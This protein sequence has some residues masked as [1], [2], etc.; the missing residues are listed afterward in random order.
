MIRFSESTIQPAA[1]DNLVKQLMEQVG[2]PDSY[3]EEELRRM[4]DEGCAAA[5][6]ILKSMDARLD[7]AGANFPVADRR[8][9]EMV[10]FIMI[11][12]TLGKAIDMIVAESFLAMMFGFRP[13]Q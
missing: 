3:S 2:G 4:V 6:A 9:V 10:T 12:R 8:V 11:Q 13:P 5:V 1:A 7:S